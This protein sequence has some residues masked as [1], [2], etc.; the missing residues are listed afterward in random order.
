M[1]QSVS[2]MISNIDRTKL[3]NN[4]QKVL[5]SLL[6]QTSNDG[7]IPR[8]TF[9]VSSATAR[10]RDLRQS[11]FGSFKVNCMSAVEFKVAYPKRRVSSAVTTQQTFY[12][13]NTSSVTVPRLK[14][15]F[16]GV[17]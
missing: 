12:K 14:K 13:I 6:R 10:I 8:T 4:T 9:K 5:L 2:K 16:K 1:K 11:D 7:W 17:I 15:A 3:T